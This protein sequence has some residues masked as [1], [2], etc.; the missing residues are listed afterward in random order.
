MSDKVKITK[1]VH[2][3]TTNGGDNWLNDEWNKTFKNQQIY[4]VSGN[5]IWLPTSESPDLFGS[6]VTSR[7]YNRHCKNETRIITELKLGKFQLK[8][9]ICE[10]CLE[11]LA[12]KI[13]SEL[14][15]EEA[16]KDV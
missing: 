4:P 12:S 1:V 2:T 10:A 13:K 3:T 16:E 11:D 15:I 14:G 8:T 9:Y 7:C 5:S 6:S